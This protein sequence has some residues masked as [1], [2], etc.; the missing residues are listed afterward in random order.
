[1]LF[2]HANRSR[3]AELA[4]PEEPGA[5]RAANAFHP[6]LGKHI[7]VEHWANALHKPQTAAKAMLGQ[8]VA[9]VPY[10]YTDQYDLG[11]EY[12]GY[13]EADGYDEV[14][15]RGDTRRRE[16]IAFWLGSRGE[17]GEPPRRRA[18][19]QM[20]QDRLGLSQRRACQITGQ[21][22]SV[23]RHRPAPLDPDKDL[24]TVLR[25]FARNRPRWGCGRAHAVLNRQEDPGAMA[26][27]RAARPAQAVQGQRLGTS[28]VPAARLRA[29]RINQVWALDYQF[30]VTAA[31]RTL[32]ILH[33]VDGRTR[34]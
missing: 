24:R 14:I 32:K 28:A 33:V 4:H 18:A 22:R 21:H 17:T 10:F 19:V 5:S 25:A 13:V 20:L 16:F 11:M 2:P 23:Q 7:R 6:L 9:Y 30:D 15:F 27:A 29:K 1:L 3:G 8:A 12:T 31:G 26:R 34:E